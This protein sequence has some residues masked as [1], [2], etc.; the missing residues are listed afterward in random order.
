MTF[1]PKYIALALGAPAAHHAAG[2]AQN[3]SFD[4]PPVRDRDISLAARCSNAS[5]AFSASN[6]S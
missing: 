3:R 5:R 6:Y 4:Q 2:P 1:R